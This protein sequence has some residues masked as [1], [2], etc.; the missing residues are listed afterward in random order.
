LIEINGAPTKPVI[1]PF[2]RSS[3]GTPHAG[4]WV[5]GHFPQFSN[6]PKGSLR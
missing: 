3:P 5:L 4:G 2:G 6:D 1:S